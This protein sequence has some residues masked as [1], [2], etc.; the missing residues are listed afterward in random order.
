MKNKGL[1]YF[2]SSLLLFVGCKRSDICK[3]E[4]VWSKFPYEKF[5]SYAYYENHNLEFI[6]TKGIV[7]FPISDVMVFN[8]FI[9]SSP[10]VYGYGF[11]GSTGEV[12]NFNH[13]SQYISL[14]GEVYNRYYF[15]IFFKVNKSG[16]KQDA[17]YSVT[18][19]YDSLYMPIDPDLMATYITDTIELKD[20][21]GNKVATM[22][23]GKG[24][25]SFTDEKGVRWER[26]R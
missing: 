4:Q 2:L 12:F 10:E 7:S 16:V 15:G 11:R 24:V 25:V 17:R 20:N 21:E 8:D 14:S 26:L 1:I 19:N 13:S 9:Y 6:S 5:F 22:V 23:A 3:T 18:L